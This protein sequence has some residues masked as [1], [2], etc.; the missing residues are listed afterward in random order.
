MCVYGVFWTLYFYVDSQRTHIINLHLNKLPITLSCFFLQNAN[1]SFALLMLGCR[2]FAYTLCKCVAYLISCWNFH[3]T[4][5]GSVNNIAYGWSCEGGIENSFTVL[6]MINTLC[7]WRK[8]QFGFSSDSLMIDGVVQLKIP[9]HEMLWL[10]ERVRAI[11]RTQRL[12]NVACLI[13]LDRLLW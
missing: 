13:K 1:A 2:V 3:T 7:K 10:I 4:L 11:Q 8:N 5:F 9:I 6:E 12:S